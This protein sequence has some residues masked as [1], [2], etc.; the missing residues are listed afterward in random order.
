MNKTFEKEIDK[1]LSLIEE[2]DFNSKIKEI[3]TKITKLRDAIASNDFHYIKLLTEQIREDTDFEGIPYIE[4]ESKKPEVL[5]I[6][7]NAYYLIDRLSILAFKNISEHKFDK[8]IDELNVPASV[9]YKTL[10]LL[11]EGSKK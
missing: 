9:V 2:Y 4:K 3:A 11:I 5:R 7:Q 6:Q 8:K 10:K 1:F